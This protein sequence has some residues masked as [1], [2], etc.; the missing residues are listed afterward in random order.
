MTQQSRAD[1]VTRGT[2]CPNLVTHKQQMPVARIGVAGPSASTATF[3]TEMADTIPATQAA[4]L[5]PSI[6]PPLS[7]AAG[8]EMPDM[9]STVLGLRLS[10]CGKSMG[11][12][13]T[14]RLVGAM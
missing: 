7:L 12:K 6:A 2:L 14:K 13:S 3:D 1:L 5:E 8:A 10:C 9:W 4:P 11:L